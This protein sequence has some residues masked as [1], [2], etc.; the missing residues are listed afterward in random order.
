MK[1]E[2]IF[3]TVLAVIGVL[4]GISLIYITLKYPYEFKDDLKS[5]IIL[6]IINFILLI[7]VVIMG[8]K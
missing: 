8:V 1:P 2:F 4:I 6:T 5:D 7:I 3:L